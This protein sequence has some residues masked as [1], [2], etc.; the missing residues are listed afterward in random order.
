MEKTTK[1]S[2]KTLMNIATLL[3]ITYMSLKLAFSGIISSEVA[4]G[5]MVFGA[6]IL[7]FSSIV[8]KIALTLVSI[9]LMSFIFAQSTGQPIEGILVKVALIV[10]VIIITYLKLKSLFSNSK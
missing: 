10:I 2:A 4:A 7:V 3:S 9:T 5:I 1:S 6:F 8:L